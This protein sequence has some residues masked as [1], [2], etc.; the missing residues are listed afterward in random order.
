MRK[1]IV[2]ALMATVITATSFGAT[3]L[4]ANAAELAPS[5]TV[6]ATDNINAQ[7]FIFNSVFDAEYYAEQNPD[8]VAALGT[9]AKVLFAHYLTNGIKEGRNASAT[10]NFDAY[11]S[12]NPDLVA[13]FG[14]DNTSIINYINHFVTFA[15]KE[16]RVATIEDAMSAGITVTAFGDDTKVI[17]TPTV[18][19]TKYVSHSAGSNSSVSSS[20]SNYVASSNGDNVVATSNSGNTVVSTPAASTATE[21][22]PAP[23]PVPTAAPEN[24][25]SSSSE[26]AFTGTTEGVMSYDFETNTWQEGLGSIEVQ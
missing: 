21:V 20:S 8:V 22:T 25:S 24:V 12:A 2:M 9:D 19:G 17:A 5:V 10:F 16:H 1:K 26:S 13:V 14:T 4:T 3:G 23:T 15:E 7:N 18:A 6:A 11:V